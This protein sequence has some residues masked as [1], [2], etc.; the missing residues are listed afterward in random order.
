[1]NETMNLLL[2]LQIKNWTEQSDHKAKVQTNIIY[3]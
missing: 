3:M 2:I 1:M